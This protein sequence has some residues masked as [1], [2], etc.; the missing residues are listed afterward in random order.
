MILTAALVVHWEVVVSIR[1]AGTVEPGNVGVSP[2]VV[3]PELD[4]GPGSLG[5][6]SAASPITHTVFLIPHLT[7]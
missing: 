1:H 4:L 7:R 2:K 6:R 3:V 5:S